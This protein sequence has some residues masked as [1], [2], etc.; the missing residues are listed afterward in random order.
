MSDKKYS[1]IKHETAAGRVEF[2][3][4]KAVWQWDQDAND[5]TS[6]LIKSL[7]NP[8]LQLEV[9]RRTP[10]ARP[11]SKS[12]PADEPKRR[13]VDDDE[14]SSDT[15]IPDSGGAGFDPYNSR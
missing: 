9:T 13:P 3:S 12:A 11:Q 15:K 7:D 10:I 4:G 2:K 5:S 1:S 8:D 14:K 6:I